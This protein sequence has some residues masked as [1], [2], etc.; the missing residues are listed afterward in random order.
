M[1]RP[2]NCCGCSAC[3]NVCTKKC[4]TMKEDKLGF[5]YPV[6]DNNQCNNCGL[7]TKVC[8][9][10]HKGKPSKAP[11]AWGGYSSNQEI[12]K[13]SSSGGIFSIL[14]KLVID[15]GGVVF[16]AAFSN[17][18][19]QIQHVC[20]DNADDLYKLRG[21]KY[22]QSNIGN[23][24]SQVRKFLENDR[25]VMFSGTPCQI[26]G[27]RLYLGKDYD[28]LLTVE[29]I[30]HG[31]PSPKIY[32]KYINYIEKKLGSTVKGVFFR[33]ELGGGYADN[34]G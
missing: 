17:D 22:V 34:E 13:G 1:I 15:N 27:L 10:I 33:D 18:N 26:D 24:Y 16:G 32:K 12:R 31:V 9:A 29:V 2:T 28:N 3:V 30:C 8:P 6:C 11:Y 21:S 14:A 4:I 5:F 23:T 25:S 19:R 20:I 7:C